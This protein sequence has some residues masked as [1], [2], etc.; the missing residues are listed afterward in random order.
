MD[1]GRLKLLAQTASWY[2][3]EGLDQE[4][5]ARR[6]GR[7]R[8]MVSRLLKE[9]REQGLIE[10]R[11]RY[12][13]KTDVELGRRLCQTF[14]L[15]GASVLADPPAD[16]TLLIRRLGELG[17][18]CLQQ[19]L[20]DD[21]KI[22]VSWG[23]AVHE[24]ISSLPNLPLRDAQVIQILGA[25]GE[26]DPLIYGAELA[27]WLAQKLSA[28]YR[29]VHAPLL[30]EKDAVAQG[31]RQDRTIAETLDLA[32]QVKVT[33]IGVG[34]AVP[35]HLS[36]FWRSAFLSEA[37][38]ATLRKS[39]I[40]GDLLARPL[41][42]NGRIVDNSLNRRVIG[43]NPKKLRSIPTVIAVA[44]GAVKAPAILAALRGGYANVLVTDSAAASA[45]LTLQEEDGYLNQ[46]K[47]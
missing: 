13:L 4:T 38:L 30:I 20:H 19:Q 22:G 12:P 40:V 29:Y 25:I 15:A 46:G 9:A 33:V 26:G 37:E 47:R 16:Y 6:I 24:V 34:I 8:S 23:T 32:A 28:T 31:L 21:I 7:S 43:L 2:Y 27:R 1:T 42:A 10:I 3:E 14:D 44:G 39:G 5:I 45:V 36:A 35:V 41:D 18:R 17:A 11:V